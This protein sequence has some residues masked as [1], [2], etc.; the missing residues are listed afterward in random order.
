MVYNCVRYGSLADLDESVEDDEELDRNEV[1][2]V[3]IVNCFT[4]C[5]QLQ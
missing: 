4:R 3:E 5:V 2:L 1:V